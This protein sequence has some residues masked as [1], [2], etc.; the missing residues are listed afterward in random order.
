MWG[1]WERI[2]LLQEGK[3][4]AANQEA[5]HDWS[6]LKYTHTL[7]HAPGYL[8]ICSEARSWW[9]K[10]PRRK[11]LC[12]LTTQTAL[13]MSFQILVCMWYYK[14]YTLFLEI[15]LL[16]YPE[17][18]LPYTQKHAFKNV[19]SETQ[20]QECIFFDSRCLFFLF[21]RILPL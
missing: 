21:Y 2:C 4:S 12:L 18:V 3:I 8:D 13:L 15:N 11:G 6:C 5:I 20:A 14:N 10:Y 7:S 19:D 17:N 9:G 1:P 16:V